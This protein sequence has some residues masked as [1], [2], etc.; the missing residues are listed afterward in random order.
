ML[1]A[2]LSAFSEGRITSFAQ[3]LDA[4]VPFDP[5]VSICFFAHNSPR[6]VIRICEKILAVR[7]EDDPSSHSISSR[8]IDQGI[9]LHC[10]EVTSQIYG[11]DQCQDLKRIGCGLFTIPQIASN[12]FKISENACR[13]K[14]TKWQKSGAV[15]IIDTI[16][17]SGGAGR[18]INLYCIS[19]PSLI[20]IIHEVV[21]LE[22]LIRDMLHECAYCHT[23]MLIDINTIPTGWEPKC[24]GCKR[25]LY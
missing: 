6:N 21:P 14:V 8:A 4:E 22:D 2:R 10:H 13:N 11:D 9:L 15:I 23:E 25:N 18:P 16:V 5:D 20:R 1:S 7:G 3:L 17:G 24:V 12:V 19:D